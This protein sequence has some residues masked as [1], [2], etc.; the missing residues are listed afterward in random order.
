M[1]VDGA[2][3]SEYISKEAVAGSDV[4][5][6]LDANL[7]KV[8]EEALKQNIEDIANGKYGDKH[9][10]KAGA[11][12][13]M[14]INSGEV[15]A[16]ASY[17]DYNPEK[18]SEEYSEDNTGRYTNRAISSAYPPGSTFKMA[19]ATAALDTGE[20]TTKTRINDTG[21]YPYSY[22]PVCWYYRII[23]ADMDT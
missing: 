1:T 18:F 3:T 7:Q 22:H 11:V 16:M 2:I 21:V 4:I 9:D 20:I 8:A 5:L 6:T 12:V 10:A 23:E 15:L 13:V 17:P 19:V 14:D